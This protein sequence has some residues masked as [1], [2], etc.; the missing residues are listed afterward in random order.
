MDKIIIKEDFIPEID[1]LMDL[2]NDVE[3]YAYTDD[4]IKLKNAIS[5]SL[6]V[7]TAWDNEKLVG[8]IRVVGDGYTIIYIQDILI[9]KNYQ[10]QGVGSYLLK[11]ILERYKL[12][13]QIVLMTDQTEKTINFYQKNGMVKASD[14]NCVTF[15]K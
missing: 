10:S 8:L 3:W 4:K 9:L 11:L 2:Y 12:I 13:R 15:V 1:Q 14:Y 7:L 5:N 6:K